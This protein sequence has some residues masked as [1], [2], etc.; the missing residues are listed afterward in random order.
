M[1][2]SFDRA[3][4]QPTPDQPA[5]DQNASQQNTVKKA[6]SASLPY[7]AERG[8]S[9]IDDRDCVSCHRVSFTVWAHASALDAGFDVDQDQL[10]TWVDWSYQALLKQDDKQV[11][12][13]SRNLDGVAQFLFATQTI[14]ASESQRS[15]REQL[16]KLLE[17]GQQQDGS[18]DAAGQLPR[19]K[20]PEQETR[21]V[22]TAWNRW[23]GKST[24]LSDAVA[25]NAAAFLQADQQMAS[26]EALAVQLLNS[27]DATQHQRIVESILQDQNEDGGWGWIRQQP[28]DALATGQML[29]VLSTLPR[30]DATAAAIHSARQYLLNTQKSDGTWDVKGTKKNKQDKI[31]ETAVYWGTCWAVI[32]LL[33]SENSQQ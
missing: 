13:G 15:Q 14:P 9:W 29:Y 6:V 21:Y 26:T 8:Q 7:I 20:R 5:P 30:N 32:G 12:V 1:V 23:L 3:A 25:E 10:N 27:T 24:G 33:K 19:Q 18:W 16:L 2:L 22:S 31:E 28:S 17:V 11:V 4:A